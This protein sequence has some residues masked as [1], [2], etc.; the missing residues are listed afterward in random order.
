VKF[1]GFLQALL[2]DFL[3]NP[4]FSVFLSW[5]HF[6]ASFFDAAFVNSFLFSP[7]LFA[8]L[9]VVSRL[10]DEVVGSLFYFVFPPLRRLFH[11]M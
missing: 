4:D 3:L 1:F 9:P 6:C 5:F 10:K 2:S 11:F 7:L 8:F